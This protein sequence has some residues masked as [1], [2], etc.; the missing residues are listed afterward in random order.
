MPDWLIFLAV[1]LLLG[2]GWFIGRSQAL[3]FIPDSSPPQSSSRLFKGLNYL[4]NEQPDQAIHYFVSMLEE[5]SESID[6]QIILA[7]LFRKQGE[8][9]RAITIHQRLLARP[10]L[11]EAT[12]DRIHIE[13]AQNYYSAGLHDRAEQLLLDLVR[14]KSSGKATDLLFSIWED[15]KEWDQIIEI[16]PTLKFLTESAKARVVGAACELFV[17]QPDTGFRYLTLAERHR[18]DSVMLNYHFAEA[19]LADKA[20]RKA[21]KRLKKVVALDQ[22]MIPVVLPVARRCFEHGVWGLNYH[23]LLNEW[24]Q[25]H[26][27]FSLVKEIFSILMREEGV[28]SAK[29]FLSDY[30]QTHPSIPGLVQL[31]DLHLQTGHWEDT[32]TVKMFRGLCDQI[33][34]HDMKYQCQKCGYQT[35]KMYWQCPGCRAWESIRPIYGLN[36]E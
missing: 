26:P 4:I 29:V 28:D 22:S 27:S 25:I 30:L 15:Q 5:D 31:V 12:I 2:I 36:A 7:K 17:R 33:I 16:T 6:L 32:S 3:Y 14:S 20:Y 1:I 9:D 11:T 24:F 8:L 21:I 18:A 19:H 34:D 13:L 23:S 35:M 10:N